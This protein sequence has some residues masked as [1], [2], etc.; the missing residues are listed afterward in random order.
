MVYYFAFGSNL[1]LEQMAKRCPDSRYVGRAGLLDYQWQI[2]QRG[3]ANIVPCA[4]RCVHGLVY[5]INSVDEAQLDRNEGVNSGAYERKYLDVILHPA[6]EVMRVST[7]AVMGL[8]DRIRDIDPARYEQRPRIESDVLV[9]L[10]TRF[11]TPDRPRLE[12]VDRM[13]YGIR[14]AVQ[15]GVPSAYFRNEVRSYI[16]MRT[17]VTAR[18]ARRS[19]PIVRPSPEAHRTVCSTSAWPGEDPARRPRSRSLSMLDRP[20]HRSTHRRN[21]STAP[22]DRC[23]IIDGD[24][25]E[26]SRFYSNDQDYWGR[27]SASH[28]RL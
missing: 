12:Y 28:P 7:R 10:S 19:G 3:F 26:G 8:F 18:N 4:G 23:V 15:L 2:N 6:P 1:W 21:F 17:P 16:P 22:A 20:T 14:D 13:N 24:P 5:N 9:Y 11:I 25:Q 27:T